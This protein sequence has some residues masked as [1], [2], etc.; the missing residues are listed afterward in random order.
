MAAV[1]AWS[2]SSLAAEKGTAKASEIGTWQYWE[3]LETGNLP[4]TGSP[5]ATRSADAVKY[6]RIKIGGISYRVGV[7]TP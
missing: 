6:E 2:G 7:D 4:H 5:S 1:L 3:A